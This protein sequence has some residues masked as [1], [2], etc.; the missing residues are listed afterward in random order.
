M[1]LQQEVGL[2]VR[3]VH[4]VRVHLHRTE[5]GEVLVHLVLVVPHGQLGVLLA[6]RQDLEHLLKAGRLVQAL[7]EVTQGLVR[8]IVVGGNAA[9]SRSINAWE[10]KKYVSKKDSDISTFAPCE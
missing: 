5:L 10:P 4:G 3:T 9:E 1:T 8:K 7:I 6:V 2:G